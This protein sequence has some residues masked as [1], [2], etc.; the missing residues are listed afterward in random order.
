MADGQARRRP[1]RPERSGQHVESSTGGAA[2]D[3]DPMPRRG[4]RHVPE[5]S[6]DPGDPADHQAEDHRAGHRGKD[7]PASAGRGDDLRDTVD[8]AVGGP[9]GATAIARRAAALVSTLTGRAPES[10]VSLERCDGGWRVGVE[11]V[12]VA[13][14]PDSADILAVYDV[15]LDD[16]GDL[17]SYQRTRRYPRGQLEREHRR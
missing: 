5:A 13:R 2:P 17:I 11:V 16:H 8:S 7:D 15:R 4:D 6:E 12:E 14:I 1:G 9:R 10:T 3:A